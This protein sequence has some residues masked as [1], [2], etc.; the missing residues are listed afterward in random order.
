M[1]K[2]DQER[3]VWFGS[4]ATPGA[5]LD[6]VATPRIAHSAGASCEAAYQVARGKPLAIGRAPDNDVHL[7]D[8]SV[9]QYH[10]RVSVTADGAILVEDL[11]STNGTYVNGERITRHT[12][13]D[14]ELVRIY[15]NYVL[16][17]SHQATPM[18][19]ATKANRV[20]AD[21][22]TLTGLYT[23][24]YLLVRM[25]EGFMLAKRRNEELALL[26]LDVDDF[27]KIMEAHGPAAGDAVLREVARVVG[28]IL[29]PEDVF[30]RYEN[31]TFG[32]LLRDQGEANVAVLAQRIRRTV[33]NHSFLCDG[34]KIDITV[35][36][37]ISFLARTI[38]TPMDFLS[39]VLSNL[40]KARRAG[41]DTIN[42]SRSLRDV[43][44]PTNG[45]NVA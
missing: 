41:A 32:L 29:R 42:G 20:N 27:A 18:P 21:R 23:R 30:A 24:T 19:E 35:S 11:A 38:K 25:D 39:A 34:N 44:Q 5:A 10:A 43:V 4:L 31:H 12:L 14:G 45:R 8:Q 37:G 22:D 36:L 33:K 6:R 17:F 2:E 13:R 26:M 16:K 3:T 15:P 7:T 1:A 40:A 9:S 28:A